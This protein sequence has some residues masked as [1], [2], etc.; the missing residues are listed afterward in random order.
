MAVYWQ[1]P[2]LLAGGTQAA[3]APTAHES[4]EAAH[5]S[6]QVPRYFLLGTIIRLLIEMIKPFMTKRISR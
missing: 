1:R 5:C 3:A 6:C 2:S 4:A